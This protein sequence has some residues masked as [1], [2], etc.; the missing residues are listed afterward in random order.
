MSDGSEDEQKSNHNFDLDD[1]A[2][3]S[4][5]DDPTIRLDAIRSA[6]KLLSIDC[7]PPID[8][9]IQSNF[10]PIF[11]QYLTYDKYPDLQ[12]EAAWALT[13]IASGSSYQTQAVAD[14][15]ALPPLLYLLNSRHSNVC[16]QAVWALGN[17]I[18]KKRNTFFS[19]LLNSNVYLY[20]Y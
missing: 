20:N 14:A 5:S 4:K 11:V 7:N 16:E 3:K 6:R 12:F 2:L 19:F 13:N 10:L 17:L 15:N 1:L 8:K 9:L 18:G